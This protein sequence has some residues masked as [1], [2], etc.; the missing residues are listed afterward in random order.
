MMSERKYCNEIN[1]ENYR[2]IK[3]FLFRLN[4]TLCTAHPPLSM[5]NMRNAIQALCTVCRVKS[6]LNFK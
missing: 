6:C 2:P 1:L 5:L 3:N 4:Y